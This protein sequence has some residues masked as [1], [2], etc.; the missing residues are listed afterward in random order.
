MSRS[1]TWLREH[2]LFFAILLAITTAIGMTCISLWIYHV[3]DVSRLDI[4]RPGYEKVRQSVK[5]NEENTKFAP[6]GNLDQ[7][8]LKQFDTLFGKARKDLDGNG[9]FDSNVLDDDQLKIVPA[10]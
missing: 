4:S 6:T 7:T 2:K 1:I 9:K 10:Q 8:A 5:R 3:N